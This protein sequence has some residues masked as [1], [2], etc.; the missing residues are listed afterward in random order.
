MLS[1]KL[2]MGS[3]G[4]GV[5]A[6]QDEVLADNPLLYWKLDE[7]S[8]IA[9]VDSGSILLDGVHTNG[10]TVNQ[11]GLINSGA[12][13][14]SVL[15]DG[16]NDHTISPTSASLGNATLP[17]DMD[18]WIS[19]TTTLATKVPIALRDNS[20]LS[21]GN[22]YVV[23]INFSGGAGTISVISGDSG[24]DVTSTTTTLNAVNPHH[25]GIRRFGG[26][27]FL[28]IDGALEDSQPHGSYFNNGDLRLLA[29]VNWGGTTPVA[30]QYFPGHLDEIAVY[31]SISGAR[32]I[33]HHAAG[34]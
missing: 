16:S 22:I 19:W 32:L 26:T 23:V 20:G 27:M 33:A 13:G 21:N 1:R 29:G 28:Q 17:R 34:V 10:P 12:V 15:Y 3:A 4:N 14:K 31:S 9:A 24:S 7:I 11:T 8:G 25:I 30:G 18:F 5:G 6:Y 2:L